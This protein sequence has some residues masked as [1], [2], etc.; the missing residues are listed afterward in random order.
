MGAIDLTW[1]Q[2]SSLVILTGLWLLR[3]SIEDKDK[4]EV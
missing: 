1:L 2:Y 3:M 4:G